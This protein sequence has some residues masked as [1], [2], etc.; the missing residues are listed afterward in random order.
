VETI[1]GRVDQFGVAEPVV[2]QKGNDIVVELPGLKKAQFDRVKKQ[3]GRT[4]QLEFKICDDESDFMA[5][6]AKTLPKDSPIKV[7]TDSYDGK[8]KRGTI[9]YTYLQVHEKDK[10]ALETFIR[11]LKLPKD[12]QIL[13]G[14]E[15][16]KTEKGQKTPD[17]VFITYYLRRR[18]ELTGEY[19]SDAEVNWDEK[20]GR[21]EVSLT[22]DRT[23]AD[24]FENVSGNNIG[25]RMAI[26]LDNKV[27][28]APV[29]QD[30]ISGGRARITLGGFK[31]P[32]KLQNEARDLA[33]VLRTGALPAPLRKTFERQ[34]GPS[35]GKDAIENGTLAFI[36]GLALVVLFILYYYRG[37]GLIC[38]IALVINFL[39]I[40]AIMA[41][42]Q[43]DADA[44]RASLDWCSQ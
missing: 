4:A 27:N 6:A 14:R 9:A 29:L 43:R 23:G 37:A 32:F 12:R 41:G 8:K 35:L 19:I 1:R 20:T 34:V 13:L 42:L 30:R 31:D 25:Y 16:Q 38:D 18:T 28:S 17:T 10:K 22:F 5:K 33:A 2:L 24:I 3:I 15:Q 40:A 39:F 7:R 44:Y 21:P 26:V 11:T 36:I